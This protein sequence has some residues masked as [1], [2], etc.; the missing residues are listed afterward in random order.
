MAP[1]TAARLRLWWW[2]PEGLRFQSVPYLPFAVGGVGH[3]GQGPVQQ[4]YLTGGWWRTMPMRHSMS[5]WLGRHVGRMRRKRMRRPARA[6][7]PSMLWAAMEGC[8]CGSKACRQD[9]RNCNDVLTFVL[10]ARLWTLAWKTRRLIPVVETRLG[11]GA[12]RIIEGARDLEGNNLD[13]EMTCLDWGTQPPEH[14]A[15]LPST[16][17]VQTCVSGASEVKLLTGR[18]AI[19]GAACGFTGRNSR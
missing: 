6:A 5:R 4:K 11:I 3:Y 12:T 8:R 2:L 7:G 14:D 19:G 10:T 18:C 16:H 17:P 15:T 9:L 1:C 13:L